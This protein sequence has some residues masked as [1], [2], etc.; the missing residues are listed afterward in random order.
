MTARLIVAAA[1]VGGLATLAAAQ[2]PTDMTRK[3]A[4][5]LYAAGGFPI[6][7]DRPTNSCGDAASPRITFVDINGDGQKE[8]LFIDTN[9]RCYKGEGRYFAVAGKDAGGVWR[10]LI[11]GPGSIAA[12]G[13]Q[14]DGWFDMTVTSRDCARPYRYE[15]GRY[16]PA[17]ACGARIAAKP[18]PASPAPA[19]ATKPAPVATAPAKGLTADD[20]TAIFRAAG[21]TKTSFGWSLCPEDSLRE[22]ATIEEKGDLNGDGRPDVVVV[23]SGTFCYGMTGMGFALVSKQ[24]NGS[25][26][27]VPGAGGQ[28]IPEF[29]TT[30]G[31]GGWP[32]IE[33]GGPG[34]CFP[35]WRHGPRG[36]D[37]HRQKEYQAGACARR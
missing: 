14:T 18:A 11:R 30:K 26:Q 34:F 33:I 36:Y 21:A 23:Q 8:A 13:T 5:Q 24:A 6:S 28:G 37:F 1:M 10:S 25:W 27:T 32:D 16:V 2:N 7:N 12:S 3:E 31:T 29:L 22:A 20:R 4:A 9:A 19:P 35:I 15:G 17:G